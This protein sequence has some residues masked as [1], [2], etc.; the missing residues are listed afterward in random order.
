[1]NCAV[2]SVTV[3]HRFSPVYNPL[4]YSLMVECGGVRQDPDG[5]LGLIQK[6]HKWA[7]YNF[8]CLAVTLLFKTVDIMCVLWKPH[9]S[10]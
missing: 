10:S 1:M 8:A 7:S 4:D 9:V 2:T 5:R 6:G 3:S